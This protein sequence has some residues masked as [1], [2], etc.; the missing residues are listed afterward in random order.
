MVD[1]N[2]FMVDLR[3]VD[4]AALLGYTIPIYPIIVKQIS[5]LI[6]AQK[7][8]TSGTWIAVGYRPACAV[9]GR[10]WFKIWNPNPA[11]N[12]NTHFGLS[13]NENMEQQDGQD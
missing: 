6:S 8:D 9:S 12:E 5:M 4:P 10:L 7:I 1:I 2:P 13:T 11:L 3:M